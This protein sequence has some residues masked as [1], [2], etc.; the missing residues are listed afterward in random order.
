MS[1]EGI[2][3]ENF[4]ALTKTGINAPT[5]SC[6]HHAVFHSFLVDDIKQYSATNTSHR[7][8]WIELLRVT[9]K[10]TPALSKIRENTDGCAEKYRC[11]SAI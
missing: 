2:V 8:H 1:I 7:K 5:K 9:K 4:S 6:P 11:A 10:L 3:L